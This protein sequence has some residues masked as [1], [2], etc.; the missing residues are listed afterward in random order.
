[1]K[2]ERSSGII[3][4]PTS[5]PGA[6][7]IG[8][9]GPA[10]HRWVEF[11][12][13]TGCTLWQVLPLGPTGY[14]DSPYQCFSAFA[15]NP[16]L[17]SPEALQADGLLTAS[18]LADLPAF[19]TEKVDFGWAIHWKLAILDVAFEHFQA[20]RPAA[21]LAEM[22]RFRAVEAGWLDDFAL[23]MALKDAH[24]GAPWVTWEPALRDRHPQALAGALEE[25]AVAIQRHIF[26]QFIFFRQWHAL[27]DAAHKAGLK[28][29][30]DAPIFVAH[31][32]A[33]V[34]A[35]PELFYLDKRGR[36]TV[37]AGVPPDYFSPTGQ[38]WGNPLYRWDLHKAS[39]YSWWIRRIQAVLELVDI[40]RLDH[41][42]G[43]VAYWEVSGS[44]KTAEKGRWAP[45]PGMDFL[46]ALQESLGDLP[47]IAEDLGVITPD[48]D[49]L[50]DHFELPGMRILQFGFG[51]GP[52]DPFLPHNYPV[53]TVVYTG[54]HDN[55][56]AL[57]WYK[58]VPEAEKDFCRRYL[59]RDAKNISWDLIRASWASVAIFALAPLQD[60]LG[61]DNSA[62]MNYPGNPSG[63]WNWRMPENAADAA[64]QKSIKEFNYLYL[65]LNPLEAKKDAE[66]VKKAKTGK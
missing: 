20:D 66:A 14:G 38:L 42:R 61:L 28:L 49:E 56:T 55:D 53:N 1:M 24:G 13:N 46:Q 34:W 18:D 23:F 36:P 64:L 63:N 12:A 60:F 22:E 40:I 47:L 7:G 15:G 30:G 37:V 44:A 32:S 65:R 25:H 21:L 3:L 43:F 29:I 2:F 50:R 10:A 51:A 57:G 58:R 33:D 4:H 52:E 6:Y 8:D 9:I 41:F 27:R 35:N 45:A 5:L 19:P 31:D 26:R 62:R 17:I 39:G 54:T 16:Y 11:L 48:V 59:G